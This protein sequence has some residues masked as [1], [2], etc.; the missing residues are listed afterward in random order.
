MKGRLVVAL[1]ILLVVAATRLPFLTSSLWAWD[2][3]L[4]ARALERGFH[5]DFALS[6]QRPQPPGYL[7]YVA[8]AALV[9]LVTGDSNTALVL[10]SVAGSALCAALIFLV[11]R[12]FSRT[13]LALLAAAGFAANPVAWTYAEVAYPYALLGALS[14]GVAGLFA[15]VREPNG[16]FAHVRGVLFASAALGVAAGFR[17][18][19]LLL[20]GPLWLWLVAPQ[21]WRV[22]GAAALA[23]GASMLTWL[24]PTVVLSDGPGAYLTALMRQTESVG[25]SYSVAAQGP[26]A[27]AHNLAF[28]A[29]ALGWGLLP[30]AV[31]LAALGIGPLLMRRA[32]GGPPGGAF[33]PFW[34]LP[35]VLFYVTVHIGEWG[36][37]LSILPGLYVLVA[38]LLERP[39]AAM[40]TVRPG[41][42]VAGAL[43]A[44]APALVFLLGTDRFSAYAL[45]RHNR[46]VAARVAYTRAHFPPERTI[47]LAREDYLRVRYY[48]PEYRAWYYDPQPYRAD[49][50]RKRATGATAIVIFTAGLVPR[51]DVDVRH[52]QI[53]EE[54]TIAYV[55]IRSGAI[56]E[57]FGERYVVQEAR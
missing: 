26:D 47:V 18:D 45:D 34:I 36:Y 50:S 6:E 54:V 5:V 49:Q 8:S 32:R 30:F 29:A 44:L 43:V 51:Q 42:K 40:S 20:L 37:V 14:V 24:V 38:A 10:V 28:T 56:V 21:S 17:Q 15:A 12:R 4:Y 31:I 41:W 16:R 2:S 33:F 53:T 1:A 27:L 22:R 57:F 39:V 35:A 52:V 7:F 19:L 25:S 48:L 13:G 11:A 9:R 46:A 3:V 23:V 55:P